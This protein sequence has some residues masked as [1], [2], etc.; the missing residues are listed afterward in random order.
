MSED[1]VHFETDDREEDNVRD[2]LEP[3][4]TKQI[5]VTDPVVIQTIVEALS[6]RTRL[7]ILKC[8]QAK[9]AGLTATEL[10][11]LVNKRVPTVLYHLERLREAG[12]VY[13]ELKPRM[14]GDKRGVKHWMIANQQLVLD[15]NLD[16]FSF[17]HRTLNSY[18]L[19]FLSYIKTRNIV[20]QDSLEAATIQDI[21]SHQRVNEEFASVIKEHLTMDTI[22]ELLGNLLDEEF[23][24][25]DKIEKGVL[26]V[27]KKNYLRDKA[28]P[29]LN[30]EFKKI[31]EGI[32]DSM[33]SK[34]SNEL[35]KRRVNT[36]QLFRTF[37]WD[38]AIENGLIV[39]IPIRMTIE[40]IA[41]RYGISLGIA[42]KIRNLLLST[43]NYAV[44]RTERLFLR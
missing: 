40:D 9:S 21:I 18:I 24:R 7:F 43:G 27:V 31:F 14:E 39:R 44:D 33:L 29:L 12:L 10:G 26:A 30:I 11:K 42:V 3:E 19:S 15:I 37:I 41:T 1:E 36:S 17:L 28:V 34:I 20:G 8:L 16:T 22:A 32:N 4:I 2:I 23:T 35:L 25:I 13:D 38:I 5:V 6:E